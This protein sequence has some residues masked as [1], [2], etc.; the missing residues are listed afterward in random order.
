[1]PQRTKYRTWIDPDGPWEEN[2]LMI[3]PSGLMLQISFSNDSFFGEKCMIYQTKPMNPL[4]EKVFLKHK[5]ACLKVDWVAA[6]KKAQAL[7]K[8]ERLKE[9]IG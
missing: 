7:L 5:D 8:S 3:H 4:N 2:Y 9:L 1:M 6:Q